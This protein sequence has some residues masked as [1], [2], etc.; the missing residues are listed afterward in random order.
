MKQAVSRTRESLSS[1]IEGIAALTRTVDEQALEHLES[2]LLTSDLGVQT[3]T[4]ILDALRDRARRK[5]IEGGEELRDL[6]KEQ[7]IAILE[8]PQREIPTPADATQSHVPG[9][10][11]RHRQNHHQR[12]ARRLEP[13]PK[14]L[15]ALCAADTSEPPPSSSLKSGPPA[16]ALK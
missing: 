3:T 13:R 11:Q 14:P 6:L 1:K 2:A 15:R 10:R 7:M 12:Q 4:A 9:R 8:A 5:A 16:P